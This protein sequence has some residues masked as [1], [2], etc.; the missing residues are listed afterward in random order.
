MKYLKRPN[1]P[2]C[3]ANK[4][5]RVHNWS[6][7]SQSQKRAIWR[8]L[9]KMQDSF[10]AYC[11]KKIEKN[12][13]QIEHFYPK[14]QDTGDGRTYEHLTFTWD[15]LFGSCVNSEHCGQFKD[16][17]GNLSPI[18]YSPSK[19]IKPDV[20]P[21]E[22]FLTFTYSG[23]VRAKNSLTEDGKHRAKESI[24]VLNLN[25]ASLKDSRRD[26]IR[27][28]EVRIREI[29]NIAANVANNEFHELIN[30]FREDISRSEHRTALENV[31]L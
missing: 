11:E 16:R 27:I 2:T 3:L 6:S 31:L 26:V 23:E 7:I 25:A 10:C 17:E 22:T 28:Y 1:A 18:P 19:L 9:N 30:Q 29:L 13:R 5:F 15:N 20:H 14:K 8:V 12:N 4:D 24:R 21:P